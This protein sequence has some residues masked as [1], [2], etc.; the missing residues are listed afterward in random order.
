MLPAPFTVA[1]HRYVPL[2]LPHL[3]DCMQKKKKKSSDT[4]NDVISAAIHP[5]H[6]LQ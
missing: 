2:W 5:V 3:G 4:R 6:R 1:F